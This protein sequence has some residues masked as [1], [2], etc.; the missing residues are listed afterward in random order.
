MKKIIG[1]VVK[2]GDISPDGTFAVKNKCITNSYK[3]VGI[4]DG[5]SAEYL[6][7]EC[8]HIKKDLQVGRYY[9]GYNVVG[10]VQELIDM[11]L[12]RL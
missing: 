7:Y 6:D 8:E 11:E 1:Y 5:K 9:F 10:N 12:A 2:K 4:Y 3:I